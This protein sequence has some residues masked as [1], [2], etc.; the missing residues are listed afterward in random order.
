MHSAYEHATRPGDPIL[1]LQVAHMTRQA[2]SK[3]FYTALSAGYNVAISAAFDAGT[4]MVAAMG[5][6]QGDPSQYL[7]PPGHPHHGEQW[8]ATNPNW[9]KCQHCNPPVHGEVVLVSRERPQVQNE[10]SR[11]V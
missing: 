11:T 1:R 6:R 4:A 5:F 10:R 8:R 2:F 9:R 3:G 7:H